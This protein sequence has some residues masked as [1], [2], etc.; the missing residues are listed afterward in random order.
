MRYKD[1]N[2]NS[3][4]ACN[5]T[6]KM[7]LCQKKERVFYYSK[8][9]HNCSSWGSKILRITPLVK[10]KLEDLIYNYNSRRKK[11][12]VKLDKLREKN[13]EIDHMPTL[14][15][16]QDLINNRPKKWQRQ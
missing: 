8:G 16:I 11:L 15:Q 2:C 9:S 10:E 6:L 3:Y 7:L 12:H 13:I 14:K 1:K 4:E 5:R